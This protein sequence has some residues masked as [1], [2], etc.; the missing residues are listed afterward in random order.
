[1]TTFLKPSDLPPPET[2]IE[3][4]DGSIGPLMWHFAPEGSI[5]MHAIAE[6]NGF[7]FTCRYMAVELNAD[8]ELIARLEQGDDGDALLKAWRPLVVPPEGWALGGLYDTEDGP[9][10]CFIRPASPVQEP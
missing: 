2:L 3:Y 8:H 6:E 4:P 7:D 9:C 5:D 10:A 1:M